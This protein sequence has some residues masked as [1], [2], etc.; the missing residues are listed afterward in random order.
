MAGALGID[1]MRLFS[2]TFRE[3]LNY[4]KGVRRREAREENHFRRIAWLIAKANEDPKNKLP[5][6]YDFWSIPQIDGDIREINQ[7][8][9]DEA[10][11]RKQKLLKAWLPNN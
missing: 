4:A 8:T 7:M 11:A 1:P 6:Y 3:F 2:F 5:Q 10:K 9:A